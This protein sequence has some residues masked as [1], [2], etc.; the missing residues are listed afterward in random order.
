MRISMTCGLTRAPGR[1]VTVVA[2]LLATAAPA[3]ADDARSPNAHFETAPPPAGFVIRDL[4][5]SAIAPTLP[6]GERPV[7]AHGD[8][9]AGGADADEGL[10][11]AGSDG[12]TVRAFDPFRDDAAEAEGF[13]PSTTLPVDAETGE[14]SPGP[15]DVRVDDT[16]ES[17]VT[18][19][20]RGFSAPEDFGAADAPT[21]LPLKPGESLA[22]E[23]GEGL[24]TL[25]QMAQDGT[26]DPHLP[27]VLTRLRKALTDQ[28]LISF[29]DLVD[30][31]Y[32]SEQFPL[33]MHPARSPGDS[34][35]QFSCEFFTICDISKAYRLNDIVSLLVV[36]VGRTA[37][38]DLI[39]V[40]LELRMWDGVVVRSLIFY[41]PASAK[42]L[43]AFG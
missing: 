20:E 27:Y 9:S 43:S 3:L 16:F 33:A 32:F 24:T 35:N 28:D 40:T 41:N 14:L 15:L 22:L 39:E 38:G 7:G 37:D 31:P 4:T 18:L 12:D 1:G 5:P 21:E 25:F 34:L 13:A 17:G 23:P 2:A 19:G 30:P 10:Y 26:G 6:G 8:A 29:L 36:G 42:L 11:D